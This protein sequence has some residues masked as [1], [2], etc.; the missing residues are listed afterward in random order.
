MFYFGWEVCIR[1]YTSKAIAEDGRGEVVTEPEEIY[2][3]AVEFRHISLDP[4]ILFSIIIIVLFLLDIA[5]RKF[6]W[7]W[8]HEIIRDKRAERAMSDK[9][10]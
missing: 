9:K 10:R 8:L 3:N 6:K 1:W 7:K 5:V 4:R 2:E